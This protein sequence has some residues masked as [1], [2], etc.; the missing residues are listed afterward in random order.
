M[1]KQ[2]KIRLATCAAAL[3]AVMLALAAIG[4]VVQS[5]II[6][7]LDFG[8][9]LQNNN[10][11][12]AKVTVNEVV[13]KSEIPQSEALVLL[14]ERDAKENEP[15]KQGNEQKGKQQ[16]QQNAAPEQPK[17]PT[18]QQ[19]Q[20]QNKILEEEQLVFEGNLK[21]FL[22]SG[23]DE[24]FVRFLDKTY[25][26]ETI[27]QLLDFA[28][29]LMGDNNPVKSIVDI[30]DWLKNGVNDLR[31]SME[32][33]KASVSEFYLYFSDDK[34]TLYTLA[35]GVYFDK[36]NLLLY[37]KDDIGLFALG[38][39]LDLKN[40]MLYTPVDAWQR[41]FGFTAL[42]D[43]LSPVLSMDYDT[44]RIKFEYGG[45]DWMVQ[46]WKGRYTVGLGAEIGLYYKDPAVLLDYYHCATDDMLIPMSMQLYLGSFKILERK[47]TEQWWL[48]GF[49]LAPLILK[50]YLMLKG[51][52]DFGD[53]KMTKA[54][55]QAANNPS[56]WNTSVST[57]QSG[58]KV[59]FGW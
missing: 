35:S 2:K 51:T 23:P 53:E 47:E 16:P 44:T 28:E 31:I 3:A 24:K 33:V 30:I 37:G 45:R 13:Q 18:A 58:S 21:T 14:E 26:N 9:K 1:R 27:I 48:T 6:E 29:Y 15:A 17:Q 54:F 46:L 42:F 41:N 52:L 57:Q 20:E 22:A 25:Q 43:L 4:P 8:T 19:L 5:P 32:P 55:I 56:G 11:S 36:D 38:Y 10:S 49:T 50:D 12:A 40:L 59:S 39:D 7:Q 34:G